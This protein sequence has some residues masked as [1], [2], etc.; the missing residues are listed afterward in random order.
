MA[1]ANPPIRSAMKPQTEMTFGDLSEEQ[2]EVERKP[3]E[4]QV[5]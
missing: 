2:S 4:I 5:R 1:K 3:E